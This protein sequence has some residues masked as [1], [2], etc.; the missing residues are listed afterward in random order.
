MKPT[1]DQL[2]P[3]RVVSGKI[4]VAQA[5]LSAFIASPHYEAA[6]KAGHVIQMV[7]ADGTMAQQISCPQDR[8]ACCEDVGWLEAENLRLREEN[9]RL[10]GYETDRAVCCM[11]NE[12]DAKR[13]RG[14]LRDLVNAHPRCGKCGQLNAAEINLCCLTRRVLGAPELAPALRAALE[15]LKP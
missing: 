6:L 12:N 1:E 10:A 3:P 4:Y 14:L 5:D 11:D 9:A 7:R 15:A 13:F 2:H 8:L